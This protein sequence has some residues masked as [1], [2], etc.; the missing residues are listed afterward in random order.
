[1]A[2]VMRLRSE[3]EVCIFILFLC[4]R[5][6]GVRGEGNEMRNLTYYKNRSNTPM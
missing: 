3:L 6:R 2:E 4:G 5:G 1:M